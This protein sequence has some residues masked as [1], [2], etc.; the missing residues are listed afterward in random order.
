MDYSIFPAVISILFFIM[1]I[2]SE[3]RWRSILFYFVSAATMFIAAGLSILPYATQV[4]HISAYNITLNSNTIMTIGA[5]NETTSNPLV[6]GNFLFIY[7]IGEVL[8]AVIAAII[9]ALEIFYIRTKAK[10]IG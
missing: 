6:P 2:V 9:G 1:A 7:M 5:H 4:V 8:F 10:L 3:G